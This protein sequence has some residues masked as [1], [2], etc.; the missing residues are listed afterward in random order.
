MTGASAISIAHSGWMASP[1]HCKNILRASFTTMGA[2]TA[3]SADGMA[4]YTTVDFQ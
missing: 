2:G 3:Q 1:D 4:W